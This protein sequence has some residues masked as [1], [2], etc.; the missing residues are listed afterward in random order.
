M[1]VFTYEYTDTFAGEANYSWVKRGSVSVGDISDYGYDGTHGYAQASRRMEAHAVR[2]VK[3]R[4]D[5][6]GVRCRRE[7]WGEIIVLRPYGYNTVLFITF[8]E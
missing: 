3:A 2:R 7:K 1:N 6:T 4:V 5:L 8:A